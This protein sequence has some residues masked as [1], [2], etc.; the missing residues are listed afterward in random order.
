MALDPFVGEISIFAGNFAPRGWA[1]CAGQ[2]LP[3]SQNTALF[4]LLGTNYGGDGRTTFGLPDL[5]ERSP[6]HAGGSAGPGLQPRFT[7][8]TGGQAAVSLASSEMPSHSHSLQTANAATVSS[9]S[10][11]TRL[12]PSSGGNIYRDPT[13]PVSMAANVMLASGGGQPHNNRQPYLTLN[14]IIALQGVFP[15]RS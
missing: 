13:H 6:L 1:F 4:S 7:G 12:A 5:R 11:T 8:E 9:P 15:P 14:Y 2:L 10:A 3:I